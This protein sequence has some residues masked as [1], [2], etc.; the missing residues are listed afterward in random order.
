V[1]LNM[2]TDY[3]IFWKTFGTVANFLAIGEPSLPFTAQTYSPHWLFLIKRIIWISIYLSIYTKPSRWLHHAHIPHIR[4]FR[5]AI[6]Q[7]LDRSSFHSN[8]VRQ[9]SSLI[10]DISRES[11]WF[12]WWTGSVAPDFG[13]VHVRCVLGV[14]CCSWRCRGVSANVCLV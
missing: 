14:S 8:E 3:D 12:K 7:L 11:G 4:R 5:Q 10:R 1:N 6:N 13:N 2:Y 9:I